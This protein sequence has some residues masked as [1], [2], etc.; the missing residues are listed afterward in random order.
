MLC[1]LSKVQLL[2]HLLQS[3][4]ADLKVPSYIA[5]L[6]MIDKIVMGPFWRYLQTTTASILESSHIYTRMV[7]QFDIWGN[8][9]H[10]ITEGEE[11]LFDAKCSQLDADIVAKKLFLPSSDEYL[12]EEVL[13][14]IFKAQ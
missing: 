8:D 9:A 2:N 6:G 14:L 4:L 13:R 1:Y 11:K 5:A 10:L 12:V 7:H 3:V